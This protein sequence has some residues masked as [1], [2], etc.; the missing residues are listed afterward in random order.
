VLLIGSLAYAA[1]KRKAAKSLDRNAD[2][3]HEEEA[4]TAE[5]LKAVAEKDQKL[6]DTGDTVTIEVDGLNNIKGPLASTK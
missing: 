4:L 5:L 6:Q 2:N 3:I 1:D